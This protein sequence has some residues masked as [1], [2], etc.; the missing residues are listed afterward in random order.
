MKCNTDD[1]IL[2]NHI[3]FCLCKILLQSV[4][5][6]ME[7]ECQLKQTLSPISQ[8]P[9]LQPKQFN[10]RNDLPRSLRLS[11]LPPD[12][13]IFQFLHVMVYVLEQQTPAKPYRGTL[14]NYQTVK[15]IIKVRIFR[16]THTIVPHY[17]TSSHQ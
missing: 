5:K 13:A 3:A 9:I 10:K 4:W 12:R 17:N 6:M 16:G 14:H 2:F 1:I 15:I 8:S 11:V 7:G